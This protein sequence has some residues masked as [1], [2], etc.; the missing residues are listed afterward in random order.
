[1]FPITTSSR[2]TLKNVQSQLEWINI[3]KEYKCRWRTK[4]SS[5]MKYLALMT[6]GSSPDSIIASPRGTGQ[7]IVDYGV[8]NFI[9][10]FNLLILLGV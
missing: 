4:N 7:E 3:N 6:S 5:R 1:M 2:D 10:F 9:K 8:P